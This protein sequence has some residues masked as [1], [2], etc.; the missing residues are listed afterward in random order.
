MTGAKHLD[1][2]GN[3]E[4]PRH[5][6]I[7]QAVL[8]CWLYEQLYKITPTVVLFYKTWGNFAEFTL[9]VEA[10]KVKIE[11]DINGIYNVFYR[12]YDVYNEIET[13]MKWY[14]GDE[15]P[16]RLEKKYDGCTFMGKPSCNY[17]SYCWGDD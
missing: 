16:P 7:G 6:H 15:L 14:N 3:T 12:E 4:L 11:S 9:S 8:Y 1:N 10:Q 13:M 17:Y 2:D 5:E